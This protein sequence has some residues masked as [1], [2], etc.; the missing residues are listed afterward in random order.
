MGTTLDLGGKT[1]STTVILSIFSLRSQTG[2]ALSIGSSLGRKS[3]AVVETLVVV[4]VVVVVVFVV[5]IEKSISGFTL[6]LLVLLY[7]SSKTFI[8]RFEMF[9]CVSSDPN[10][11]FVYDFF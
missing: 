4:V 10:G 3:A 6:L 1:A 9:F 2:L 5:N 8:Q 11:Y 7:P